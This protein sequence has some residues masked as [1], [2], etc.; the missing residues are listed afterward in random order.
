MFRKFR[1][2][3]LITVFAF[4]AIDAVLTKLRS[5]DWKHSL[6]VVIYPINGDGSEA[7]ENYIKTLDQDRFQTIAEFIKREAEHYQLPVVDPVTVKLS[8][9]IDELPP[10][11]PEDRNVFGVMWWSLKLRYWA[12]QINNYHGPHPDIRMFV[13]YYDPD[14]Q[15]VLQHSLGLEKGMIGRVNAFASKRLEAKNNVIIAHEMLHTVGATDKYDPRDNQ[16]RYP[17]GYAE[18]DL[19]PRFPQSK[20]EIMGGRIPISGSKSAIPPSLSKVVIG[21]QTAREI[22]WLD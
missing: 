9:P 19:Q 22:K 3:I 16:P 11:P 7:A 4:V 17:D 1:I 14:T 6:W 12:S 13:L 10:A 18:P 2:F 20:A 8:S 15:P 5:T 21:E